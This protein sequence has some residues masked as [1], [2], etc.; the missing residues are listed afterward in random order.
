MSGLTAPYL[1]SCRTTTICG[2]GGDGYRAARCGIER[3]A[4]CGAAAQDASQRRDLR[5]GT[6][7]RAAERDPRQARAR[8]KAAVG[9]Q[10]FTDP[11]DHPAVK[12]AYDMLTR[13]DVKSSARRS[14]DGPLGRAVLNA[15]A[16]LEGV[17]PDPGFD[18]E[19]PRP[20]RRRRR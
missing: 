17:E 9:T 14:Q 6:H 20:E 2:R 11:L 7:R 16:V 4:L 12:R 3:G 15:A 18:R 13:E 19:R 5:G 10:R 1:P 8:T